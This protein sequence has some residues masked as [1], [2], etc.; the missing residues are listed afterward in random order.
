[1]AID[2]EFL[3]PDDRPALLGITRP[4]HLATTDAV[5]AELGYKVHAA[6]SHEDFLNL[7]SQVQYQVVM[8]DELFGSGS[9]AE[10]TSLLTIQT[11]PMTMRR[12][13]TIILLG[14]SYQ[15]LNAMQAYQQSVHAVVNPQELNVLL[16]Q[17][18][19]KTVEVNDLFLNVYR[20]S[21]NRIAQGKV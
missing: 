11:M 4:E 3:S 15:T 10:N 5:L 13:A 6:T 19:Q 1:M 7:F 18:V 20:E 2:F 21:Q 14:E 9:A 8:L 16:G 12:H 17:I